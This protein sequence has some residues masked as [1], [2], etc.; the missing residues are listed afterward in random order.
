MCLSSSTSNN[1][2]LGCTNG[3]VAN[4]W[5][6]CIDQGSVRIRCPKDYFPCNE[7]AD[8]KE[9]WKNDW[10]ENGERIR[11][12]GNEF[13]C[14]PDCKNHGGPKECLDECKHP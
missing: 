2:T 5:T 1:E 9:D 7:L 4:I 12:I 11:K 8:H 3:N 6:G 13:T 14:S 10:E